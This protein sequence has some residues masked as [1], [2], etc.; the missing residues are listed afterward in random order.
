MFTS[1][2]MPLPKTGHVTESAEDSGIWLIGGKISLYFVVVFGSGSLD[3]GLKGLQMKP[4]MYLVG[5]FMMIATTI[6]ASPRGRA[7]RI[8]FPIGI[9]LYVTW[10]LLS[11]LWTA[12][13]PGFTAM[14]NIEL[15]TVLG[16]LFLA[17]FLPRDVVLH[18]LKNSYYVVVG[19]IML[20]PVI[21]PGRAMTSLSLEAGTGPSST[22]TSWRPSCC[23]AP[24]SC[25]SARNVAGCGSRRSG[26]R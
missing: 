23:S 15:T 24:C 22:R 13:L 19:L 4:S 21:Q 9:T 14:T 2:R 12:F 1:L 7:L 10:W 17:G 25:S 3:D 8:A 20:A 16:M 18:T 26:S 5:T 6:L 11:V